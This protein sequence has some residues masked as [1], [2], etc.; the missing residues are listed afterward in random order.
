MKYTLLLLVASFCFFA[1]CKKSDNTLPDVK[2]L[3]HSN[4]DTVYFSKSDTINFI[5][6][7]T[8]D[9]FSIFLSDKNLKM[10]DTVVIKTPIIKGQVIKFLQ[11]NF[12]ISN[13]QN[14]ELIAPLTTTVYITI[15]QY[16]FYNTPIIYGMKVD[17]FYTP[18][19]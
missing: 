11:S 7:P 4:I 17:I 16:F 6:A 5:T 12:A 2:P 10:W 19:V 3:V 15:Y 13:P 18:K 14:L 1:S 9:T 8:I